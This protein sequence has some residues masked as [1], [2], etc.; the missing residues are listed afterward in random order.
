MSAADVLL[1][2]QLILFCVS[3]TMCVL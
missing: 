3:L 1:Q 2:V